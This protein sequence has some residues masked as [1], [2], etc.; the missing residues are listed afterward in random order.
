MLQDIAVLTGGT[1]IS[2]EVGLSLEKASLEDLGHAKRIIVSKE[3]TT[4]V[5]VP[6]PRPISRA[7]VSRSSARSMRPPPTM[8]ARSSRSAWRSS[9]VGSP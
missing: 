4:L 7:A 6:A 2:E 9:P 3:E 1:V 5:A 8:T